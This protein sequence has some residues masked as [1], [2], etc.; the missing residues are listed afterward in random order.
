[1][2]YTAA[3]GVGQCWQVHGLSRMRRACYA[4]HRPGSCQSTTNFE[5]ILRAAVAALWVTQGAKAMALIGVEGSEHARLRSIFAKS[6]DAANI[7][8]ATGSLA[9]AAAS[10]LATLPSRQAA[11]ADGSFDVEIGALAVELTK[12]VVRKARVLLQRCCGFLITICWVLVLG[13]TQALHERCQPPGDTPVQ[14]AL[15]CQCQLCAD[16]CTQN[17]AWQVFLFKSGQQHQAV[18][19]VSMLRSAGAI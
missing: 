19:F 3:F 12:D 16:I 2:I 14:S 18:F 8:A 4:V 17:L 7:E 10:L 11:N 5:C 1:M 15:C 13:C 6:F 9:E